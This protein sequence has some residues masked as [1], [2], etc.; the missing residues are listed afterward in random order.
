MN[1]VKWRGNKR[2]R[3]GADKGQR[4]G[5]AEGTDTVQRERDVLL[6]MHLSR[7]SQL[8]ARQCTLDVCMRWALSMFTL[9][10]YKCMHVYVCVCVAQGLC[11]CE[12]CP[13]PLASVGLQVSPGGW[14]K[15]PTMP[16]VFTAHTQRIRPAWQTGTRYYHV[17]RCCFWFHS[18]FLFTKTKYA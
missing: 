11:M 13:L 8:R 4:E 15:T 9:H 17:C 2:G 12:L 18:D 16:I 1:V 14:D 3:D 7:F 10:V 6:F 5:S